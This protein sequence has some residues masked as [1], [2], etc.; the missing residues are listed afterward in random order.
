MTILA[1]LSTLLLATNIF[2]TL[3]GR[4]SIVILN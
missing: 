1:E 2:T 4:S 3:L